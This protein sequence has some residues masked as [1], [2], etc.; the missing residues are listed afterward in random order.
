MVCVG[1]AVPGEDGRD[2][3]VLVLHVKLYWATVAVRAACLRYSLSK[4][5][6]GLLFEH[7]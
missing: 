4:R 1:R 2:G 7:L 3:G 5:H 6:A